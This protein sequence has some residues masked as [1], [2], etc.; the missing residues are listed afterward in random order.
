MVELILQHELKK[1]NTYIEFHILWS[2]ARAVFNSV[3]KLNCWIHAPLALNSNILKYN[4][5]FEKDKN[6]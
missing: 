1:R 2:R 4:M 6:I 5:K 3:L